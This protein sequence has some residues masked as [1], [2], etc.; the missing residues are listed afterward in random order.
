MSANKSHIL[1]PLYTFMACTN[2][3]EFCE[4][5]KTSFLQFRLAATSCK[6]FHN[7]GLPLNAPNLC[8]AKICVQNL[9]KLH[10]LEAAR[11]DSF[12]EDHLT[13]NCTIMSF[14]TQC[15][16]RLVFNFLETNQLWVVSYGRERY[17]MRLPPLVLLVPRFVRHLSSL[18][19]LNLKSV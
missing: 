5:L 2:A 10:S 13:F 3:L 14:A 8:A 6:K 19:T 1:L 12:K 7:A 11:V 18:R 16:R 17:P 9:Y 4:Y 15:K